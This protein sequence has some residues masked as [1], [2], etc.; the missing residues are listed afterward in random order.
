ML[1][2]LSDVFSASQHELRQLLN[3]LKGLVHGLLLDCLLALGKVEALA[4]WPLELRLF[5]ELAPVVEEED[6]RLRVQLVKHVE[7][8]RS[9]GGCQGEEVLELSSRSLVLEE[10]GHHCR[11]FSNEVQVDD[12]EVLFKGQ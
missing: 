10:V 2:I 11:I 7:R 12:Q 9:V 6:E 8:M 1:G 4:E 5:L 3:E